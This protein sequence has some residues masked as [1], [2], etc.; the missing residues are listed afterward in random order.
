GMSGMMSDEYRLAVAERVHL[1]LHSRAREG[2]P[3]GNNA[4]GYAS[5]NGIH[6][7]EAPIVREIFKTYAGGQKSVRDIVLDLNDRGVPGPGQRGDHRWIVP[8]LQYML[9]NERYAGRVVWNKSQWVKD[10]ETGVH[11]QRTRP[12]SEWVIREGVALVDRKTWD[13]V[14]VKLAQRRN[15][16]S[17]RG[18]AQRKYPLS[19][20]LTCGTCGHILQLIGKAGHRVYCC[21][22]N[23]LA[24][25]KACT[26]RLRVSL[27]VVTE[28]LIEPALEDLLSPAAV[29]RGAA[30]IRA[31]MREAPVKPS[32]NLKDIDAKTAK[33]ARL[34]KS[35]DLDPDMAEAVFAKLELERAALRA[36]ARPRPV[37]AVFGAEAEFRKQ[38]KT[39][40]RDLAGEDAHAARA[41][42]TTIYGPR[43]TCKPNGDHLVAEYPQP[44]LV[45]QAA[46]AGRGGRV[47]LKMAHAI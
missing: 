22:N 16:F 28:R 17:R 13:T 24:G 9:R 33:I 40:R 12:Q 3:T 6:P 1:A 32:V 20:L 41:A 36:A 37:G 19:G 23:R 2:R 35:G 47:P 15:S 5:D 27:E 46:T 29:E 26:N 25:P 7:T 10:P 39:L 21:G 42:L 45:Q 4:Y 43:I 14:Q 44:S 18:G 38:V 30:R 31:A 34:V 11:K 8:S